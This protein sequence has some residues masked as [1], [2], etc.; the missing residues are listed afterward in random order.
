MYRR[1]FDSSVER[2]TRSPTLPYES[3]DSTRTAVPKP[4]RG[5]VVSDTKFRPINTKQYSFGRNNTSRQNHCRSRS[6]NITFHL[7]TR[8]KRTKHE[9]GWLTKIQTKHK[10]DPILIVQYSFVYHHTKPCC[11][12]AAPLL[13][14]CSPSP[15]WRSLSRSLFFTY[16]NTKYIYIPI[17][18]GTDIIFFG[19]KKL[20]IP[21]AAARATI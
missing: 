18:L 21:V 17:Y 16:L 9:L 14:S 19:G 5:R 20:C 8:L 7:Y 15:L 6:L 13:Y 4:T 1:Y 11:F 2:S 12:R 3:M 10:L